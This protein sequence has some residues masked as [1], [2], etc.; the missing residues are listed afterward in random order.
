MLLALASTGS[1]AGGRA[2]DDD[3]DDGPLSPTTTIT[4]TIDVTGCDGATRS[5]ADEESWGSY[6]TSESA[7]YDDAIDL[8]HLRVGIMDPYGT[9]LCAVDNLK[10]FRSSETT[11][12]YYGTLDASLFTTGESYRC[13]VVANQE[14]FDFNHITTEAQRFTVADL[15]NAAGLSE[16]RVPM[17]GLQTFTAMPDVDTQNAGQIDL[18]RA[19]AKCRIRLSSALQA[20]GYA[21]ENLRLCL[22]NRSG[23]IIPAHNRDVDATTHLS[24]NSDHAYYCFNPVSGR[25]TAIV[26]LQSEPGRTDGSMIA[27]FP[28]QQNRTTTPTYLTL[29][30]RDRLGNLLSYN[31]D[32]KD[33]TAGTLLRDLKRNHV[34]DFEITG[35]SHGLD[36]T[37]DVSDWD[38]VSEDIDFTTHISGDLDLKWVKGT[39]SALN[40]ASKRVTVLTGTPAEATFHIK[41]PLGA[42]WV[43]S[44]TNSNYLAF[45]TTDAEG[46]TA[47]TATVT[48]NISS[49]AGTARI[50]VLALLDSN[51]LQHEAKITFYVRYMD[52]TSI[53]VSQLSDWVV[54]QP[55]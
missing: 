53:K 4:F 33:Y 34:Y 24:Y 6:Y 16:M 35:F 48:G 26:A 7:S 23:N 54:I 30:I 3:G 44:I 14:K 27:Y 46:N 12:R 1:C 9:L 55:I 36:L 42:T 17:W 18:L 45:V 8:D 39:Y 32:F 37:L 47:Y 25:D 28:E 5:A 38:E 10:C 49:D 40:E 50:K 51:A 11:Y 15:P 41:S 29:D 20:S 43:A 22:Y 19:A 21:M 13:V 31:V 52:G 2:P